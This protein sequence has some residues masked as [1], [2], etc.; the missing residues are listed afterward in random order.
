M[1]LRRSLCSLKPASD[2]AELLPIHSNIELSTSFALPTFR[3]FAIHQ[4]IDSIC[5]PEAHASLHRPTLR[6]PQTATK[7]ALNFS[8]LAIQDKTR[9]PEPLTT[10]N[11]R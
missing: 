4:L 5:I 10:Y 9:T 1:D 11:S 7:A 6:Q 8:A 2:T 3:V